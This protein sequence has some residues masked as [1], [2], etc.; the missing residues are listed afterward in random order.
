MPNTLRMKPVMAPLEVLV[1]SVQ[2]NSFGIPV[3][4]IDLL[5]EKEPASGEMSAPVRRIDEI[6][7]L[8][9][10]DFYLFP[11][12]LKLKKSLRSSLASAVIRIDGMT[13]IQSVSPAQI[14]LLPMVIRKHLKIPWV[15]AAALP[16]DPN[17][18][19]ILLLLDFNIPD[20][21]KTFQ[22]NASAI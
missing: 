12:W 19:D 21:S 10:A 1:F 13:G 9:N 7:Q 14:R 8:T 5:L 3:Q 18:R 6:L 2:M 17:Q 16:V 11:S 4:E 22:P 20:I 15:W